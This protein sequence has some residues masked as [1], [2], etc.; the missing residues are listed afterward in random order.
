MKVICLFVLCLFS[1]NSFA[2]D[3][4]RVGVLAFGTVN[5]ELTIMQ[6]NDVAK[7]NGLE[8]EIKK[9]PSKNAV[10]IALQAD[11]V[12]VIVSDY[13]WV[14]RQRAKGADFTFYPYSKAV[15]GV[16]VR[17]ELK[18]E[19]LMHLENKK[20]GIAGGPVNMTWLITRAYTKSKYK[21][22]IKEY[23][24]PTFASP[25]ILNK[26]VLDGSLD[27]AINFWHYNARLES[28]GMK[29]LISLK[30]ML[31]EMGIENDI[32]FIGWV[33][34]EKF[35]KENKKIINSFLQ[36]SYETKKI[37]DNSNLQW[38]RIKKQMKVE[39]EVTYKALING[40]RSG[41]PKVFTSA[42]KESAKKV[43]DILV[44]EGGKK[45]VGDSNSLQKGTFWNFTPKIEW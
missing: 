36:A 21:K 17:P 27:A 42:Q 19:D 8:L 22:D 34:S 43:F 24:L 23:T 6:L 30:S 18:I 15:G 9:L 25:P 37:L 40:Y 29:K 28:E 41:I 45:L 10:S 14:S 4:L 16:Y 13:I 12:D 44:Q 11:A 35:A 2:L 5:W 3:K 33:F 38:L 1:I 31:N 20:L 32:P 39:N 26:K 7:K